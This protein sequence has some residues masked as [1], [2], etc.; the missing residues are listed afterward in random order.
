MNVDHMMSLTIGSLNDRPSTPAQPKV[1]EDDRR[2]S[3]Y[4]RAIRR[5]LSHEDAM[6]KAKQ[7]LRRNYSKE[8]KIQTLG[9]LLSLRRQYESAKAMVKD[10]AEVMGINYETLAAWWRDKAKYL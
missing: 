9:Q 7:P 10:Q 4:K 2:Y 5:G 3:R 8:F 1:Y 6:E